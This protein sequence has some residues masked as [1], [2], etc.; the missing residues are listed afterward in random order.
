MV[1][2]SGLSGIRPVAVV[3]ASVGALCAALAAGACLIAPPPDLPVLP[4]QA[5]SIMHEAVSPP[6][7]VIV[8][9]AQS[10]MEFSIPVSMAKPG[11]A[12]FYEVIYDRNTSNPNIFVH[13]TLAPVIADGGTEILTVTLKPPS[14]QVCPHRIEFFVAARFQSDGMF[15]A[16]GGD[17]ALWTYFANGFPS[18][19]PAFD[20]GTGDFPEAGDQ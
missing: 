12:F 15:N 18:G 7:G 3:V 16:V 5:P 4:D 14:G 9:W 6:E 19:C 17:V 2:D 10:G 11:E 1:R 20:A 13:Q 8:D